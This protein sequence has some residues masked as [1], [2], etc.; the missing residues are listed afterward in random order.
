MTAREHAATADKLLT[1][2]AARE[3]ELVE[4]GDDERLQLAVTGAITAINRNNE[5]TLEAA[6]AHALTAIALAATEPGIEVVAER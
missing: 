6:A 2:L 1:A 5:F 3:A 4:L